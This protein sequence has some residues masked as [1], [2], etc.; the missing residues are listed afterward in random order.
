MRLTALRELRITAE[1]TLERLP[2]FLGRL[3]S[4]ERLHISVDNQGR[5]AVRLHAC[6]HSPSSRAHVGL[7]ARCVVAP[8]GA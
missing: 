7:A 6:Q 1:T 8:D 3:T 2:A 5:C 4:L